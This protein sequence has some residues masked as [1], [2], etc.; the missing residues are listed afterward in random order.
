MLQR[1]W[2][3]GKYLVTAA[4]Q[5]VTA[6]SAMHRRCKSGKIEVGLA[7]FV[8]VFEGCGCE[9]LA[10]RHKCLNVRISKAHNYKA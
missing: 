9:G 7:S 4:S 10:L 5:A 2:R 6:E 3:V 8:I 1:E